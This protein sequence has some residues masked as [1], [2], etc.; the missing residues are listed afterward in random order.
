MY[1]MNPVNGHCLFSNLLFSGTTH[2]YWPAVPQPGGTQF[3]KHKYSISQDIALTKLSHNILHRTLAWEKAFCLL[4]NGP[5][6]GLPIQIQ[7]ERV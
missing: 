5:D 4:N 2:Q 6:S 7:I 3:A 1:T